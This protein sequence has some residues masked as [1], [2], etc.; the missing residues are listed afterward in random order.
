MVLG[1]VSTNHLLGTEVEDDERD[2]DDAG[3]VHGE[4]DEFG[5]VEVLRQIS[6]LERVQRAH[7]DQQQIDAERDEHSDVRVLAT[8]Q[9]CDVRR[10]V[11]PGGGGHRVDDR[12]YGHHCYLNG[13]DETSYYHLQRH[14]TAT[15][16]KSTT[17]L[18]FQLEN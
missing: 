7:S 2:P 13:Y 18:T 17:S 11:D 16:F 5:L 12:R 14:Q 6:R 15:L 3:R 9:L 1:W 8:R 4:S 10:R